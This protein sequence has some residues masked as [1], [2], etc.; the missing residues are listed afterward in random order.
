MLIK[1]S[2]PLDIPY[3]EVTPKGVYLS[4]RKFLTGAA[5]AGAAL[6]AGGLALSRAGG[7]RHIALGLRLGGGASPG[8][9]IRLSRRHVQ[10]VSGPQGGASDLPAMRRRLLAW[11]DRHHRELP[12]RDLDPPDPYATLVS[13]AMLQQ[14]QVATVIPYY[15]RFMKRFLDSG[16]YHAIATHDERMI[17][18]ARSYSSDRGLA[19]TS[20][21]FQMLYGIRR[22]MQKRLAGDGYRMRLYVPYG[23]AWY[24]YF[25]RRLT[26]RPANIMFLL[27][28][29]LR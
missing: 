27:R 19:R 22:D 17:D 8:V 7:S 24:P 21:E 25:M 9:G 10:S 12:W 14:T 20:F 6:A 26:E 1:K 16:G 28:S 5:T 11:Y 23:S 13:E 2:S 3:S 29:L 15:L 18:A 4:R